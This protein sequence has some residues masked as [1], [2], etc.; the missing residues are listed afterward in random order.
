M[1][2]SSRNTW[3]MTIFESCPAW[4]LVEPALPEAALLDSGPLKVGLSGVF[5]LGSDGE[6]G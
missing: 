2:L 5:V 3:A 4:L 1:L 6:G